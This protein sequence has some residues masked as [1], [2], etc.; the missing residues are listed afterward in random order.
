MIGSSLLDEA[1]IEK[2]I[3]KPNE[4]FFEVR[5]GFINA[6]KQSGEAGQQKDG[7]DA[8]L[9]SWDQND[10]LQYALAY[11][12]LL[13]IRNGK[14]IESKADKQ[15][16][17]F[18]TT[19]QQPFTHHELKLEKGDTVYLLSDG[20]LDQFGGKKQKKFMVKNF[21]KLLLSLQDK[22]MNEQHTILESTIEEWKGDNEQIDDILVMG[23]RF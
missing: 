16:V 2:G 8:V 5:K 1:V 21:K 6:L 11:N 15:P 18:H 13:I 20:Y 12:S 19:E 22:N 4:I 14:L 23:V 10:T 9:C 7:M 3:T 17:G